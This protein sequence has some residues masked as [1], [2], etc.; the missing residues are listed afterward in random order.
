MDTSLNN[1]HKR[2]DIRT[3][4]VNY[5]S[6]QENK[7]K[8]AANTMREITGTMLLLQDHDSL[9]EQLTKQKATILVTRKEFGYTDDIEALLLKLHNAGFSCV[10]AKRFSRAFYRHAINSGLAVVETELP[11]TINNNAPVTVCLDKGLVTINT[12]E[13]SF[14]PY[15]GYVQQIIESGGILKAVKKELGRKDT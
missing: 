9:D 5:R 13:I 8:Q 11:A 3:T 1:Q 15:P 2:P 10:I 4:T 12:D 6:I 14:P 7:N